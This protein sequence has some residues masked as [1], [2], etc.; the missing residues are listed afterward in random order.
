M[1]IAAWFRWPMPTYP[2]PTKTKPNSVLWM[3]VTD[4][5]AHDQQA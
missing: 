2:I 3:S 4:Y 1:S 5:A